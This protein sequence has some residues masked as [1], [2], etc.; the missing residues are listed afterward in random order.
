MTAKFEFL[1]NI[2]EYKLFTMNK[3]TFKKVVFII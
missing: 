3:H 2:G 1:K